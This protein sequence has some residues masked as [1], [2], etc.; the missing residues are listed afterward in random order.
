[1]ELDRACD[2]HAAS[3]DEANDRV[4]AARAALRAILP[5]YRAAVNLEHAEHR[6]EVYSA[7]DAARAAITP[8]IA[9]L[10]ARLET[11]GEDA[12][13]RTEDGAS[14]IEAHERRQKG[15]VP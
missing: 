4:S 13:P 6:S 3:A 11:N 9:V 12:S 8:E 14:G 15:T 1:V 2:A 5:V 10:M 7:V